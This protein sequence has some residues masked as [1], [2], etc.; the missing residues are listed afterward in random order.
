M[1][2]VLPAP[3]VWSAAAVGLGALAFAA[4]VAAFPRAFTRGQDAAGR[5]MA[6]GCL[7]ILLWGVCAA[8][9]VFSAAAAFL[10][11]PAYSVPTRL[12]GWAPL[13]AA[14]AVAGGLA[15]S[16]R[17]DRLRHRRRRRAERLAIPE[18]VVVTDS[19]DEVMPLY[20]AVRTL[21]EV[22]ETNVFEH[23]Q[24][25]RWQFDD[26]LPRARVLAIKAW[27]TPRPGETDAADTSLLLARDLA[28]V[29]PTCP[30]LLF[31]PDEAALD[32]LERILSPAWRVT[33][34]K[35]TGHDWMYT[36]WV[37]AMRQYVVP[38][39]ERRYS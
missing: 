36:Q 6:A 19:A 21:D 34:L 16:I 4:V 22:T 33:R 11:G 7:G 32:E 9:G 14:A 23:P 25:L 12:A 1:L 27:T 3:V 8:V 13:A 30:I 28:E 35:T 5:A 17:V 10:G 31:G 20:H 18:Y 15:V 24:A 26:H 29:P 37:P 2:A 39:G 38:E